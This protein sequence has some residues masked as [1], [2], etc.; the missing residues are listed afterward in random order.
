MKSKLVNIL[1]KASAGLIATAMVVV[2][3]NLTSLVANA[4]TEAGIANEVTY[5]EVTYADFVKCIEAKE[6]PEYTT[7]ANVDDSYGYLFAGWFKAKSDSSENKITA[8][9]EITQGTTVYAKFVPAYVMSVK[10]Q[11][12]STTTANSESTSIRLL[13]SLDST[14]Y[15]EFGFKVESLTKNTEDHG[16][17]AKLIGE[18][19]VSKIFK[20]GIEIYNGTG[21]DTYSTDK[22]FGAESEYAASLTLKGVKDFTAIYSIQPY[23]VTVDGTKVYGLARNAHV[24]DGLEGYINVPVNL[25]SVDDVA[26]G[27]LS[28][29]YSA[30]PDGYV[31]KD[32]ERGAD[33]PEMDYTVKDGDI[34][35]CVGNVTDIT[36]N[37]ASNDLFVN[38][39][40]APEND[41]AK[42]KRTYDG[43]FY[44][45]IVSDV[46]FCNIEEE[47]PEGYTVW[48]IQY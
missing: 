35:K 9:T 16:Y 21:F 46:D 18:K 4:A 11:N 34:I 44:K 38:L 5:Q 7:V 6:A 43:T 48:N 26:A 19:K 32:V 1:K 47:Q 12:L 45:F 33:F 29:D 3:S 42:A 24:E 22:V 27:V 36:A 2:G 30:L 15:S 41:A 17:T 13:S 39:R 23:W 25:K 40:F 28:V 10:C 37:V 14:M 31:L 20:G 8:S